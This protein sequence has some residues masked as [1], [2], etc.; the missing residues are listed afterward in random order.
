MA[1]SREAV[2]QNNRS[3]EP[4]N[5]PPASNQ[6]FVGVLV[7]A[8][9]LAAVM[10]LMVLAVGRPQIE[11]TRPSME[12]PSRATT[13]DAYAASVRIERFSSAHRT[14]AGGIREVSIDGIVKNAGDK[15]VASADLRCHFQT[16]S[17][18]ERHLELPL[19]VD[20][21]LEDMDGGPL[22]PRSTRTF[23][24]RFGRFPDDLDPSPLGLEVANVRFSDEIDF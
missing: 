19:V 24:V 12:R 17:G 10:L 11:P 8:A 5:S 14:I 20:S 9:M 4:G 7:A 23:G 6:A 16:H 13:P 22:Q 18:E 15:E 21:M 2:A 3:A 1:P